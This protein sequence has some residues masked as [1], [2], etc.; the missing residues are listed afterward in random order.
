MDIVDFHSH[1]LPHADHGSSST[2]TSLTQLKLAQD[3]GVKRII[4]TPHYYPQKENPDHFIER[5]EK[6]Y[7]HLLKSLPSDAPELRVG[8][9]I[10]ICDNIEEMPLL[11]QLCIRGTK[12][13]LLELPFS[14]FS[15]SY[16]DSVSYLTY[17]GYTVVLA[18]ADRYNPSDIDALIDA[19]AK[20]QINAEALAKLFI[21]K[22]I[23]KWL[24]NGVVYAIGS[25]IHGEDK[26]AY[27]VFNNAIKKISCYIDN[28]SNMSDS[29]WNKTE[30]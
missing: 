15:K 11:D 26:K 23:K 14:D 10:L 30:K 25:D 6:C 16:V 1:I 21:G 3:F 2:A 13:L 18:H 19:G 4:L 27:K 9:E 12:V 29:I 20:V 8:A 28:V 5:R 7:A 24:D 22:H 17:N